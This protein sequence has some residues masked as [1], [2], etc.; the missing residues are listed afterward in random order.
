MTEAD[1]LASNDPVAM[2][3][4]LKGKAM[5][6]P[7][8]LRLFTYA[9]LRRF[10]ADQPSVLEL[11]ELAERF[12]DGQATDV[13]RRS[14]IAG[15]DPARDLRTLSMNLVRHCLTSPAEGYGAE[16][17]W[18]HHA[19]ASVLCA[20][21]KTDTAPQE[22]ALLRDVFPTPIIRRMPRFAPALREK[23][24]N[25]LP[26]LAQAIYNDRA[27]DR[28]PIL[29]DALEEAGCSDAAILGHCRGPGP[30]IR[31]CWVVDLIL[32]KT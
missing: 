25:L 6:T 29:A 26:R 10:L 13:E 20:K 2:L 23:N 8:K 16:M 4:Y 21:S 7:R 31:G 28:L 24:D 15:I 18:W 17:D 22:V 14:A 12:V 27:P 5:A 19:T 3:Q 9:V 30:H 11:I 32:G 1:W